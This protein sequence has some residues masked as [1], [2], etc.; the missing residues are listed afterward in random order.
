M[1]ENQTCPEHSNCFLTAALGI[2]VTVPSEAGLTGATENHYQ[3]TP[4]GALIHLDASPHRVP[5]IRSGAALPSSPRAQDFPEAFLPGQPC[6]NRPP[7][8][9]PPQDVRISTAATE[10]GHLTLCTGPLGTCATGS[11]ATGQCPPDY[12][13]PC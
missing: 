1:S 10:H 13:P 3:V 12:A 8:V 2:L 11:L 9:P 7:L 6:A 5:G 4:L